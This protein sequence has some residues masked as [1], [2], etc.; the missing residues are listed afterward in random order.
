M[1]IAPPVGALRNISRGWSR[2]ANISRRAARAE[3]G[4]ALPEP[5][6][7]RRA[8][9][10]EYARGFWTGGTLFEELGFYYVGPVDGHNVDHLVRC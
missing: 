3:A 6:H 8:Q 4:R 1:S 7:A 10:E 9:A 2:R 5:L